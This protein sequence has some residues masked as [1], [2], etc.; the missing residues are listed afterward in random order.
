MKLFPGR[1]RAAGH[2]VIDDIGTSNAPPV[3][4]ANVVYNIAQATV[5]PTAIATDASLYVLPERL[6]TSSRVYLS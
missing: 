6:H 5:L 2:L 4:Y 1:D 3:S